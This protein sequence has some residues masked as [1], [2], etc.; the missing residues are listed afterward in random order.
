MFNVTI[1]ILP[2][3]HFSFFGL[4]IKGVFTTPSFAVGGTVGSVEMDKGGTPPII[5]FHR[6]GPPMNRFFF[7]LWVFGILQKMLYRGRGV[8]LHA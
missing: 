6:G 8:V 7:H 3:S 2:F 5:D 1:D 4:L